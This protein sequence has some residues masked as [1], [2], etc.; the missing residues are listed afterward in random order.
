MRTRSVYI[1]PAQ[2]GAQLLK[3]CSREV[4]QNV[5][6]YWTPTDQQV[7]SLQSALDD[8]LRRHS[9]DRGNVLSYPLDTYHGQYAGIV[10]GGKRLIYGNFY[11]HQADWLHEDTQPV[12]VCDGGRSF[13]GV[14]FDPD[15]NQI[16]D[17]AFN[18][19]G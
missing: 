15:A 11:I 14:V 18:G 16:L 7:A 12:N 4:P 6:D 17:V 3:Q 9:A 1:F 5:S 2:D 19:E 13:F 8:Y 10:S